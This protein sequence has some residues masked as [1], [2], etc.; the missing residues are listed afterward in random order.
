MRKRI[1]AALLGLAA[2][3]AAAYVPGPGSALRHAAERARD[4]SRSREATL[5]GTFTAA[6]QKPEPRTLVLRLPLSCRFE[7]GPQV[8]DTVATPSGRADH[9]GP[10]ATLLELACPLIAYRTLTIADAEK[11]LRG[12]AEAAGADLAAAVGLDRMGDQVAI[13]LGAQPHDLSKPQM[14]LYKDSFAPA[15]LIARRDGKLADLRLYEYGNPA[16]ANWFPRLLELFQDDKLV[17][18]F[19]VTQTRGFR[20][21]ASKEED[22]DAR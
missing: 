21:G 19:E 9:E 3:S 2:V 8:K 4:G 17:A 10:D 11:V 12:T 6:G 7:N 14:W 20:E 16:A 22:E 15:R 1:P 18:R 13:L 5:Q